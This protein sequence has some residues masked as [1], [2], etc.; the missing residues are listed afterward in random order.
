M[1]DFVAGMTAAK[2]VA[3][4]IKSGSPSDRRDIIAPM[5]TSIFLIGGFVLVNV[6]LGSAA[7]DILWSVGFASLVF[8]GA[9][10]EGYC[11]RILSWKPLVWLGICSYSVYLIHQPLLELLGPLALSY[12]RPGM[13]FLIGFGILPIIV[14]VAWLFYLA[15][16]KPSLDYF[17]R[18]TALS[19]Q[20]TCPFPASASRS[21]PS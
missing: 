17:A 14:G 9:C 13:A 1:F 20:L 4:R 18:R 19:R 16:E 12:F 10:S 21:A 8:W 11:K 5:L 15:V 6:G 2:L 7:T 3:T